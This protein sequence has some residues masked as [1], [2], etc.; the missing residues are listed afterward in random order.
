MSYV[1]IRHV[2]DED[3]GVYA[4]QL[5]EPVVAEVPL[6]DDDGEPI[7]EP[8]SGEPKM[9]EEQ[10]GWGPV[11]EVVFAVDDDRWKGAQG[12]RRALGAIAGEQRELARAAI[13][14]TS[15]PETS[16]DTDVT[17]LGGAGEPL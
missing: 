14:A 15:S 9:V 1:V 10:I 16:N 17:D 2:L 12:R 4:L 11:R 5:A 3:R 13:E 7:R 8:E 6:L